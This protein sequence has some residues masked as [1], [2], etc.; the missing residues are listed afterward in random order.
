MTTIEKNNPL[1]AISHDVEL[2]EHTRSTVRTVLEL[3]DPDVLAN[4]SSTALY[5]LLRATAAEQNVRFAGHE[6][7]DRAPAVRELVAQQAELV[8]AGTQ[9]PA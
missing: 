1:A 6:M 8:M 7:A 3:G 4:A 9:V 2:C 5:G